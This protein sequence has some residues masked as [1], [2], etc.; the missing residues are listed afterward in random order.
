M[1]SSPFPELP[2]FQYYDELL[3]PL[4]LAFE[5]GAFVVVLGLV[6]GFRC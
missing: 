5:I 4:L 2:A 3:T 6:G 1:S